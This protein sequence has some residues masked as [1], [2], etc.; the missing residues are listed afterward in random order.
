MDTND[1]KNASETAKT[2][3]QSIKS[4]LSALKNRKFMAAGKECWACSKNVYAKR[5]KGKYVEVRGKKI[6]LTAIVI[7][8]LLGLFAVQSGE[9][10]KEM[11]LTE[12]AAKDQTNVYAQDGIKVYDM[13][14]CDQA[15]CGLLEN[16]TNE[17]IAQITVTVTF[18]NPQGNP[19]YESSIEVK[20]FQEM[21]RIKFNIPC[22]EDFAYFKLKDVIVQ[23]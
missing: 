3:F 12:T 23:K 14:K 15:A 9:K 7:V 18:H 19:I 21:A 6:P 17:P 8:I 1:V 13:R 4:I 2:T 11:P 20:D 22:E 5:L 16:E 10:P